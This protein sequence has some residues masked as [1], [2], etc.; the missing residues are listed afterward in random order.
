MPAVILYGPPAAGKD[1]I[2]D[3]LTTMNQS[4]QLFR[5]MKVGAGRTDGYRMTTLSGVERLRSMGG[6]IWETHRYDAL[7]IIDRMTLV[8]ML[9]TCI[10]V[11]HLGEAEAVRAV[12]RSVETQWVTAWL[13]CPRGIAAKRISARGTGDTAARMHVWDETGALPEAHIVINTAE[14]RPAGAAATIHH[15]VQAK[16]RRRNGTTNPLKLTSSQVTGSTMLSNG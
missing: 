10:P 2:T 4:Y 14:I 3:A 5:R 7:Y 8:E 13:W 6:M 12:T 16:L 1:T 9:T 11:I 15:R